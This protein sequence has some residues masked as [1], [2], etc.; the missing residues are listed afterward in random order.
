MQFQV[1]Q[2]EA[3]NR[4]R[5]TVTTPQGMSCT[6]VMADGCKLYEVEIPEGVDEREV[7]VVA[8]FLDGGSRPYGEEMVLKAP[9]PT[10]SWNDLS[11]Q[12]QAEALVADQLNEPEVKDEE[13][14]EE[15]R[16][17]DVPELVEGT[18]EPVQGLVEDAPEPPVD[19]V[20]EEVKKKPRRRKPR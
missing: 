15:P 11:P 17:E 8:Q 7:K 20:Q 2:S 10:Q 1:P 18:P 19:E 5:F 9:E 4:V 14:P 3:S 16:E 13:A 6:T 12:Q